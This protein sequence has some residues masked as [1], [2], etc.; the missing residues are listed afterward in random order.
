[1]HKNKINLKEKEFKTKPHSKS[2][3]F[4][5]AFIPVVLWDFMTDSLGSGHAAL[6]PCITSMAWS[7]W[8]WLETTASHESQCFLL[9]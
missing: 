9:L 7:S 2:E 1:M 8:L 5:T 6:A 3:V 4:L